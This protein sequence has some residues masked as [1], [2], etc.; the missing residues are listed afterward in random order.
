MTECLRLWDS[1]GVSQGKRGVLAVF[2][3]VLRQQGGTDV[4]DH[5]PITPVRAATESELGGG[6]AWLIYDYVARHFLGSLS[7]DCLLKKTKAVFT[8]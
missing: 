5:P 3:C 2:V 4:G 7:A 8:G 6:D 1:T